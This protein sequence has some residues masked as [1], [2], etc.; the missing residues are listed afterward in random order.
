MQSFDLSD[1]DILNEAVR[2]LSRHSRRDTPLYWPVR[3]GR[4]FLLHRFEGPVLYK[5]RTSVS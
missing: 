3:E 1:E 5:A 4:L 2:I